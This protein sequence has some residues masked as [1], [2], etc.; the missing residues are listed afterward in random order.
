MGPNDIF[1]TPLEREIGVLGI[2][3]YVSNKGKVPSNYNT[4]PGK[5]KNDSMYFPISNWLGE[6]AEVYHFALLYLHL[7]IN[8]NHS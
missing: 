3:M 2:D 4:S 1:A 5:K 6:I 8:F 7:K